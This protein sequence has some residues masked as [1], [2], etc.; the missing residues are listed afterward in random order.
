MFPKGPRRDE[1]L[2]RQLVQSII[3]D[4]L[5]YLRAKGRGMQSTGGR[6]AA[7]RRR[8]YSSTKLTERM[9]TRIYGST[10]EVEKF[11]ITSVSSGK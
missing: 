3:T 9:E 7:D 10:Q 4:E 2:L 1:G 5:K 6:V 11:M 8:D